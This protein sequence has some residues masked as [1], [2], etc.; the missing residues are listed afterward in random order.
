MSS[1]PNSPRCPDLAAAVAAA[2]V[3][4]S[5]GQAAKEVSRLAFQRIRELQS[6]VED[7]RLDVGAREER[8]AQ[9][10][11]QVAGL[12]KAAAAAQVGEGAGG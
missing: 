12:C 9:L 6:A 2:V 11:T 3:S 4:T 1:Q 7:A 5:A 10:E 8:I